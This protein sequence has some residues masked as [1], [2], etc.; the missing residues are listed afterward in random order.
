[1]TNRIKLD[2]SS[3][4]VAAAQRGRRVLTSVVTLVGNHDFTVFSIIP[5]VSMLI[6]VPEDIYGSW[7]AGQVYTA[8]LY[9]GFFSGGGGGGRG[10]TVRD[11][12]STA[13]RGV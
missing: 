7:Y 13:F 4:L 9:R 6:D 11:T 8:G 12:S 1:M 2:E 3:V 10:R 5:S